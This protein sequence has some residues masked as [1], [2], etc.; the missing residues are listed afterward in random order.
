MAYFF[1]PC[2]A[3]NSVKHSHASASILEESKKEENKR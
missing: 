2:G 1:A 3:Y